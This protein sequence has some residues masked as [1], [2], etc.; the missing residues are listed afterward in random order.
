MYIPENLAKKIDIF[1]TY[2]DVGLVY[3]DYQTIDYT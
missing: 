1:T 2:P 3:S